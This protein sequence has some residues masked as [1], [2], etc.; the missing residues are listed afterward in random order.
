IIIPLFENLDLEERCL[1]GYRFFETMPRRLDDEL[2]VYIHSND[3]WR[4]VVAL[5]FAIRHQRIGLLESLNWKELLRSRTRKDMITRHLAGNGVVLRTVTT[6]PGQSF[7]ENTRMFSMYSTLEKT[8]LLKH[9]ALFQTIP[10]RDI[11]HLAQIAR[12]VEVKSGDALFKEGDPG[13]DMYVIAEGRIR[14]HGREGVEI[15]I[16]EKGYVL[17]EMAILD[18]EPRSASATAIEDSK[19]LKINRTEFFELMASRIEI[20][21]G[22]IQ[23]LTYRLRNTLSLTQTNIPR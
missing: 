15:A 6:F 2:K 14:I 8:I 9:V 22:I 21:E 20:M 18:R 7:P 23:M 12:E 4:S 13:E 17:G 5:D 16:L 10:A 3:T 11:S 1:R 19:L